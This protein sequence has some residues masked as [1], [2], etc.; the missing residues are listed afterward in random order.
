MII[1]RIIG[2]NNIT[3]ILLD[4]IHKKIEINNN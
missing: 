3:L 4:K 1:K 2:K